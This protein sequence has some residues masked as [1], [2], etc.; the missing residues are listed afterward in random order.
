MRPARTARVLVVED[1]ADL[2]RAMALELE[3]GGYEVRLERD[4]PGG[5]QTI[6]RLQ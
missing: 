1:D 2:A 3:H 5:L 6:H 4:G